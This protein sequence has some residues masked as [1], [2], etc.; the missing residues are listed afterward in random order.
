[1]PDTPS[2]TVIKSFTYRGLPEQFSNTYHFSGT[3]P[4]DGNEWSTLLDAI[5]V[6]EKPTVPAGV[7]FVGGYGYEAGN[8]V[9]VFVWNY[10]DE[11]YAVPTGTFAPG[12]LDAVPG[13][14]AAWIRWRTPDFS[15]TGKRIYLRKYMH[16]VYRDA[17]SPDN[18]AATQKAAMETF[19]AKLIDGTLP[20]TFRVCGPQGAVASLPKVSTYLT[21]R[22]LKRRGKRPLA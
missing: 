13:D 19:G 1:M 18:L 7:S 14:V 11:G 3:T 12:A 16:G 6:A 2:L 15:T 4:A 9:A 20:E 5:I 8:E 10:A 21:T 22:T 17:A